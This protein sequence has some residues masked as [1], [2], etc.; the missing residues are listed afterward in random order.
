M[1]TLQETGWVGRYGLCCVVEAVA[2][3]AQ[4]TDTAA[5]AY[6]LVRVPL[7]DGTRH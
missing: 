5:K 7:Q 3:E 2:V 4:S 1:T 6:V